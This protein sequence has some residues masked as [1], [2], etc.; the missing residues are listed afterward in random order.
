MLHSLICI[1]KDEL[2]ITDRIWRENEKR[3]YIAFK[4][5]AMHFGIELVKT[6][7]IPTRKITEQ[8][9]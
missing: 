7:G 4:F 2:P 3:V 9:F 8:L 1:I 6:K 5:L